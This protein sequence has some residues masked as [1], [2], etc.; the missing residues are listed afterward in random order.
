MSGEPFSLADAEATF[1]PAAM[2][3]IDRAVSQA[4]P[5]SPELRERLR[6]LFASARGMRAEPPAADAA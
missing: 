1:G 3:H 5:L 4:P 6:A 2:E